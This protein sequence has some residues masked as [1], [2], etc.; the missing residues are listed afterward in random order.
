MTRAEA[1]QLVAEFR[2]IGKDA[3]VERTI[4]P[5]GYWVSVVLS[6][7]RQRFT[8]VIQAAAVIQRIRNTQATQGDLL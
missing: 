3:E 2:S 1:V 5:S 8:N 4:Q 7:T 6:H